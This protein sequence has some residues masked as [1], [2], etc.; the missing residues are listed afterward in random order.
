MGRSHARFVCRSTAYAAHSWHMRAA[1]RPTV[2]SDHTLW[3]PQFGTFAP[4]IGRVVMRRTGAPLQPGPPHSALTS[5]AG[6]RHGA[7]QSFRPRPRVLFEIGPSMSGRWPRDASRDGLVLSRASGHAVAARRRRGDRGQPAG[8]AQVL[9]GRCGEVGEAVAR[10]GLPGGRGG[11]GTEGSRRRQHGGA[12]RRGAGGRGAQRVPR[13]HSATG[14]RRRA[15]PGELATARC[16]PGSAHRPRSGSSRRGCQ[17]CR[18]YPDLAR[19][20][21]RCSPASR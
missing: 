13:G 1:D 16:R 11:P 5:R 6:F 19:S 21:D 12:K 10:P 3:R 15:G 18:S 8:H 17:R 20:S 4:A 14:A 2:P 7:T 9:G